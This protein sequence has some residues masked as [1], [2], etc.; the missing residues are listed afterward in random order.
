LVDQLLRRTTLQDMLCDEKQM[1]AFVSNL[2]AITSD[3][4]TQT[5]SHRLN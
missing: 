4:Q 3:I 1:D 2:V 5:K